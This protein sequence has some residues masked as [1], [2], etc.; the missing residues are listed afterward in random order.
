[1]IGDGR[2]AGHLS[3]YFDLEQIPH[4]RW[5][6]RSGTPLQEALADATHALALISDD[7]IE[8][9]VRRHRQDAA[10][11]WIHCSGSLSTDLAVGVHPLMTFAPGRYDLAAYRR[12]PFVCDHDGPPFKALF[13][14]LS[15][16]H[17]RIERDKKAL[18]HAMCVMGG[19]FSTLL[20]RKVIETFSREL[21]LPPEALHPYMNQILENVKK[22]DAPLT[23]PLA[24]R[25]MG[26][27]RRNL[28]ALSGDAAYEGVYRAFM[29][30][31]GIQS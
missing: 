19:N 4:R 7:A 20:W 12:I 2:L 11:T 16:P 17:F 29:A 26:T 5:H 30:T 24:R 31:V 1:M 15:N 13:P 23:G 27:I 18:Y 14:R 25:D 28:N 3:H 6:R 21:N 8:D 10:P 9:F 22:S